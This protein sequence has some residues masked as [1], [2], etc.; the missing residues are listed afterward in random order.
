MRE[1]SKTCLTKRECVTKQVC[2]FAKG[3]CTTKILI[4]NASA[5]L[6]NLDNLHLKNIYI[7]IQ[8][9]NYYIFC[10][11]KKSGF[12]FNKYLLMLLLF[13]QSYKYFFRYA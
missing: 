12:R 9:K 2:R 4:K 1:S 6:S 3:D 5:Q 8:L 13:L 11:N 10:K 7:G